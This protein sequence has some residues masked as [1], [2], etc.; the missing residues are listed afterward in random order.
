[1]SLLLARIAQAHR[2][3]TPLPPSDDLYW[4]NVTTLLHCDGANASTSLIDSTGMAWNPLSGGNQISTDQAKFGQSLKVV[5][6]SAAIQYRVPSVAVGTQDFTYEAFVYRTTASSF[7][8]NAQ[9]YSAN[10]LN[11]TTANKLQ[12]SDGS[13]WAVGA[14]DVPVSEWVHVEADRVAGVLYLF[15]N[16]VLAY[17]GAL[18]TSLPL[19]PFQINGMA[20]TTAYVDEFRVTVGVGRHTANFTPPAAPLGLNG[21]SEFIE[22]AIG[23]IVTLGKLVIGDGTATN[24][25]PQLATNGATGTGDWFSYSTAGLHSM[26]VDMGVPY[27]VDTVTVWHYYAD[28]R[29]YNATKT[30]VSLDGVNWT[31]IFDSATSGTYAEVSTGH[32][33][34]FTKQPIRYIRDWCNGSNANTGSHWTEVQAKRS[35]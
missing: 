18:T 5:S 22:P 10:T 29:T 26:I 6:V 15:V 11:I 33:M 21:P 19:P 28:G 9:G 14:I 7:Y 31:T 30:E 8:F 2:G 32:A 27:D 34:T 1:M 25:S 24:T 20:G 16:G 23:T 3:G 4:K 17:S 12:F 13:V 35:A